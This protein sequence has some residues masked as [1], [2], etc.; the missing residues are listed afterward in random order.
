MKKDINSQSILIGEKLAIPADTTLIDLFE[1]QILL[2]PHSTAII[3]KEKSLSY[4]ELNQKAE[5]IAYFLS[6]YFNN[7]IEFIGLMIPNSINLVAA[8]IASMK[9]GIPFIPLDIDWPKT[10]LDTIINKLNNSIILTEEKTPTYKPNKNLIFANFESINFSKKIDPKQY[11]RSNKI[12]YGFFTSGTTGVPKCALNYH[13][14]LLNRIYVMTD[15]F[16]S[17]SGHTVLQNSKHVFDSSMWQ[18][19]WPL[20]GGGKVVIPS[21]TSNL[22]LEAILKTISNNK[23]TMT[24]FVPSIFNLVVEYIYNTP[25]LKSDMKTL[26]AIL[27]GGEEANTDSCKK[28][29]SL[30]PNI[31]LINT[32]GPTEASIGNIF[33]KINNHKTN[34]AI[35]IGRPIA[36]TIAVILNNKGL[37]TNYGEIG[38]ICIGGVCLGAGYLNDCKKTNKV[39]IDNLLPEIPVDKL[40]RTGDLG[41]INDDGN[42]IFKGRNDFQVKING[43]RIEL[44][45]IEVALANIE[46]IIEARVVV[47][48]QSNNRRSLMAIYTGQ[49]FTQEQ[50][51]SILE[52][53]LPKTIIPAKFTHIKSM[54]LTHNG[55]IDR[56]KLLTIEYS[57]K[58]KDTHLEDEQHILFKEIWL[59]ILNINNVHEATHFFNEGGNSLSAV[60]LSIEVEKR[61]RKKIPF[62]FIYKN[63]TFKE[64]CSQF[65]QITFI[66]RMKEDYKQALQDIKILKTLPYNNI[67][68]PNKRFQNILLT[69]ATGFIGIH[70]LSQLS[71]NNEFT[72]YCIVRANNDDDAYQR[73]VEKF[74]YYDLFHRG[75]MNNIKPISGDLE[76]KQLGIKPNKFKLLH[77]II[78]TFIN[79]AANIGFL[80]D[81]HFHR[82][83]NVLAVANI[84]RFCTVNNKHLIHISSFSAMNKMKI[85]TTISSLDRVTLGLKPADAYGLSKWAAEMLVEDAISKGFNFTI[86]RLGEIGKSSLTKISNPSSMLTLFIKVCKELKTYPSNS[87]VID[88]TTVN[89]VAN[90]IC[91]ITSSEVIKDR[92]HI[93][94]ETPIP[95]KNL[96]TS[97]AEPY[98]VVEVNKDFFL[99]KL[100]KI[101]K[102]HVIYRESKILLTHFTH[103]NEEPIFTNANNKFDSH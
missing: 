47:K 5:K 56:K 94:E 52:S 23:I 82:K 76:K 79:S 70:I 53:V 89:L 65:E 92:K 84:V 87:C 68:E 10:R 103:L 44:G 46:G 36:N 33:Y 50:L 67:K 48:G 15:I 95:L 55:K 34:N 59:E 42:I 31:Q 21:H 80:A 77:E 75:I 22:N 74:K 16:G 102:N 45:E 93:L 37:L 24:D 69:G 99:K 57:D 20:S 19:L 30:L 63:P 90:E 7:E 13:Y 86:V 4:F 6:K 64:F 11:N 18:I 66:S 71:Q 72:I 58:L 1:N 78:D 14:G 100:K 97:E 96:I 26:K 25:E 3:H 27:I 17:P 29:I 2:S 38:E 73:I 83:A 62:Q 28:F 101:N 98:E 43:L 9:V 61:T 12:I 88:Y 39:F 49:E 32:Y 85:K 41:L 60:E 91:K 81:Y 40:Y 54:P 35:P 8:I 51:R